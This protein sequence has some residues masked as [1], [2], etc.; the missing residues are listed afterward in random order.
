M[1][2]ASFSATVGSSKLSVHNSLV[3]IAFFALCVMVVSAPITQ[4]GMSAGT[5]SMTEGN[6]IRQLA[7]VLILLFTM[8]GA[9]IHRDFRGL[10]A[11]AADIRVVLAYCW[12]SIVWAIDPSIATR[13]LALTT[14]VAFSVAIAVKSLGVTKT[15]AHVRIVLMVV[16]LASYAT[17]L[18]FPSIGIHQPEAGRD[19][20]LIGD[21]RGIYPEKNFMGAICAITVII[22]YFQEIRRLRVLNW[23]FIIASLIFLIKT[24]SKTSAALVLLALLMGHAFR[25]NN[26]R[27]WPLAFAVAM[28]GT[29]CVGVILLWYGELLLE[30]LDRDDTLTGRSQI[31]RVLI[32]YISDHWRF[33]AGYGSFWYIGSASPVYDY[34]KGGSWFEIASQGHN[35]YLDVASQIGLSGLVITLYFLIVRPVAKL[36]SHSEYNNKTGALYMASFVFLAGHN[37]TESTLLARDH[38]LQ[39]LIV[40]V[41]SMMN[42]V[43]YECAQHRYDAFTGKA[44]SNC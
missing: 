17:V 32:A 40:V 14:I 22:L 23:I 34:A 28:T 21:W 12:L 39:F 33:G 27:D 44:R 15:I 5:T 9:G 41:I 19:A 37:F 4:D 10:S 11:L 8:V 1:R 31:W 13:R 38:I 6:P 24:G 30:P 18:L 42:T 29:F 43:N 36:L 20:A 35:G 16:I 7:Y 26:H 25:A 3:S 2:T